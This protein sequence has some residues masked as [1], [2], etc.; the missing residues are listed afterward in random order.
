[1]TS[2]R[3]LARRPREQAAVFS[4]ASGPPAIGTAI[5]LLR[6]EMRQTVAND[7]QGKAYVEYLILV[8]LFGLPVAGAFVLLGLQLLDAYQHAQRIL[9]GP[10]A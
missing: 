2:R 6:F 5:A 1:M 10:I 3:A 7:E 9:T 8:V 4:I